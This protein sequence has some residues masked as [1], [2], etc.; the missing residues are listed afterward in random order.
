MKDS[1]R[2]I[3]C[4]GVTI[5]AYA[6]SL[7]PEVFYFH[8]DDYDDSDSDYDFFED[9]SN[10]SEPILPVFAQRLSPSDRRVVGGE[11]EGEDEKQ[12]LIFLNEGKKGGRDSTRRRGR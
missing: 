9:T 3:I 1:N 7:H 4:A 11:D 2:L 6:H 10:P 8:S 12:G 5:S